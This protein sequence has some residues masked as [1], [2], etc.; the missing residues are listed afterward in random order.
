M[1]INCPL[2]KKK[3]MTWDEKSTIPRKVKCRTCEKLVVFDP[4][5]RET[6]TE[7]VSERYTSSGM[8]FY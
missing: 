8:K 5:T 3:V 7:K 1:N 2:C 4:Q 6:K